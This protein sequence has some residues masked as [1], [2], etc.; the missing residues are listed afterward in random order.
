MGAEKLREMWKLIITPI[1]KAKE[2]FGFKKRLEDGNQKGKQ[3]TPEGD[4]FIEELADVAEKKEQKLRIEEKKETVQAKRKIYNL[5]AEEIYERQKNSKRRK[6]LTEQSYTAKREEVKR[7]ERARKKRLER[8]RSNQGRSNRTNYS[9]SRRYSSSKNSQYSMKET[10]STYTQGVAKR[11]RSNNKN[12]KN[13]RNIKQQNEID[14]SKRRIKQLNAIDR[15]DKIEERKPISKKSDKIIQY[16]EKYKS[17]FQRMQ[18]SYDKSTHKI[19]YD[20][21]SIYKVIDG[22]I[23]NKKDGKEET[24]KKSNEVKEFKSSY[25]FVIQPPRNNQNNETNRNGN[26]IKRNGREDGNR[27]AEHDLKNFFDL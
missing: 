24:N 5:S 13:K 2:L 4:E 20:K 3:K 10:K 22:G 26:N 6:E 18:D 7:M 1:E 12:L 14:K 25:N 19:I 23:T 17:K 9:N 11:Q 8:I 27:G 21:S 16:D 15:R